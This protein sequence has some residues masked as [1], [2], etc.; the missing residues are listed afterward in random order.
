MIRLVEVFGVHLLTLDLRQ[1]SA[2]HTQALDEVFRAAGVCDRL[3]ASSRP[4]SGSTCWRRELEQTR[5]LI[6][7]HLAFSPETDEVIQ[8]FRTAAAILEQ[9]CPEALGTYIISSTTEPAHLL[10]VL[11][12]A[13]EARLF[14]PGGGGQPGRHRPAVRGAA[15]RC[16][17]GRPSWSG[18]STCRSTA[19]TWSCAATSR[20]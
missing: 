10:E 6:P 3:R 2:R 1:H 17:D 12:L 5:P 14:R 18:S 13:R 7:T 19:A 4:T 16:S 11:L 8:T 9:Q 20:R 15:S